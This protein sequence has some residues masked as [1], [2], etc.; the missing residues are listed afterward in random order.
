MPKSMSVI[1]ESFDT[2]GYQLRQNWIYGGLRIIIP[3]DVRL[4]LR[5]GRTTLFREIRTLVV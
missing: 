3:L 5:F 1:E 4:D 2:K